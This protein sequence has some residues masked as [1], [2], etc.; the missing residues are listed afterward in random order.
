VPDLEAL[1]Q[2][3]QARRWAWDFEVHKWEDQVRQKWVPDLEALG[4]K[5]QARRWAWDFEVRKRE[6]H[7]G[8][9]YFTRNLSLHDFH[10]TI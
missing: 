3:T 7:A 9:K 5:T 8:Q 2:K 4:Q 1:G 10:C 6:D